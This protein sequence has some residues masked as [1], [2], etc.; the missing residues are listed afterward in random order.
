MYSVRK[1]THWHGDTQ[2]NMMVVNIVITGLLIWQFGSDY[3]VIFCSS[4]LLH[5]VIEVG[6]AASGIR[7][8]EVSVY[9]WKL[10]RAVDSVVRATV[11]GPAF[12]VPSFFVA[13]QVAAG[14]L[15]LAIG[16]P[17]VVVGVLSA[18]MGLADRRDIARLEPGQ[19]P[20]MSRRAMTKPG[21]VM[22]LALINSLALGALFSIPAPYRAHAFTFV[23]AYALL[24]MLFYLIN[25]N[26]GVRMVQIYDCETKSFTTPGPLF[27]ATALTYDSAYEMG[28]LISAA[29]W[30][31]FYLGLFQYAT[32]G[33][34]A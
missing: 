18:Y 30:V 10:P 27:Q 31:T 20:L 23:A 17:A 14:N 3:A 29:Y 15:A 21:A 12:C 25:Y 19:Q 34:A 13:D 32:L 5:L 7:K 26:L 4:A 9:G 33:V 22:L 24:V 11:E 1:T 28:L 16:G 8:G 6:L 2:A